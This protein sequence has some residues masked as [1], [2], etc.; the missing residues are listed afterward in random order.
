MK[1]TATHLLI[2]FLIGLFFAY[3]GFSSAIWLGSAWYKE[4]ALQKWSMNSYYWL[5]GKDAFVFY[6]LIPMWLGGMFSGL[7][8]PVTFAKKPKTA[9]VLF[10]SAIIF[11]ALGFNTLDW[12][13]SGIYGLQPGWQAWV[14]HLDIQLEA[15]NFYILTAIVPLFV[16]GLFIGLPLACFAIYGNFER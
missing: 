9:V 12:M 4:K 10:F 7:A 5:N 3:A 16:G 11:T 13:L 6:G 2:V 15:W 1:I 8:I 14:F